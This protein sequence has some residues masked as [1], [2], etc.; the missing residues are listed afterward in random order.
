MSHLRKFKRIMNNVLSRI[1][2]A[3]TP[4]LFAT[5]I[6]L[7]LSKSTATYDKALIFVTH[8]FTCTEYKDR[9]YTCQTH[10]CMANLN[11]LN[12]EKTILCKKY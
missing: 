10:K 4:L 3:V 9:L 5:Y 6:I 1:L 2:G 12:L 8:G 11:V 7:L